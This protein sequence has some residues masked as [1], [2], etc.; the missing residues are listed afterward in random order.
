M[1]INWS[2]M[3]RLWE[4]AGC[5]YHHAVVRA[6]EYEKEVREVDAK[7]R[8]LIVEFKAMRSPHSDAVSQHAHR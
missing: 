6:D 5:A 3:V 4:E 1:A 2:N 7:H 8:K